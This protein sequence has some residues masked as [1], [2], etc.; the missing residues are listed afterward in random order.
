MAY[1]NAY[2]EER[3]GIFRNAGSMRFTTRK[4]SLVGVNIPASLVDPN[5]K[6]CPALHIEGMCNMGF[7]NTAD[8]V[9]HTQEQDLPLW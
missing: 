3:W 8:H 9:A 1:N 4:A 2:V 6:V 7:G 5:C